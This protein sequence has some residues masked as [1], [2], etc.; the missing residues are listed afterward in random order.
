MHL[1]TM[2]TGLKHDK[3]IKLWTMP[4]GVFI[5]LIL[6]IKSGILASLSFLIGGLWLS[7]D[8][9]TDS[10]PLRRW[11]IIQFIWLPYRKIIPHR[12][13]FSH[14]ILLGSAIRIG[15]LLLIYYLF[16]LIFLNL[17]SKN[18]LFFIRDILEFSKG[19]NQE[20]IAIIIG[21]ESSA[22]LHVIKDINPLA[23]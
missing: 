11:G 13:I 22:I 14:G 2:A 19:Y 12:S 6:N 17:E 1:Q 16:S 21:I 10:K 15:Y 8:L 5:S 20:F 7:P 4:F 18:L 9:D 3:A 23:K